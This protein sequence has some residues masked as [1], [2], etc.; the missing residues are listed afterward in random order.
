MKV[1]ISSSFVVSLGPTRVAFGQAGATR[2]DSCMTAMLNRWSVRRFR[3]HSHLAQ[4]AANLPPDRWLSRI[5]PWMC[6]ERHTV[7]R[8]RSTWDTMIQNFCRYQHLGHWKDVLRK[9]VNFKCFGTALRWK[10]RSGQ[11]CTP[12]AGPF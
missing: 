10:V 1:E 3:M 6:R 7:G 9:R 11:A 2:P 12:K 5:L 8:L 4:Y